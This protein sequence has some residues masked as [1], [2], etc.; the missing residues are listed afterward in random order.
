M[1]SYSRILL[2]Y[3]ATREGKNALRSGAALAQ[4]LKAETHLLAVLDN[5]G[6][7]AGYEAPLIDIAEIRQQTAQEIL[8]EGVADL[9]SRGVF[10]QGHLAIGNPMVQIPSF[11]KQLDIDLIVLGHHKR[12]G[13][14]R[15]WTPN[16]DSHLLDRVCC[17][18]LVVI[19]EG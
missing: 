7:A 16:A 6:W 15:W 2:C 8:K 18:V 13:L 10:A 3:N 1:A 14:S 19:D 9:A 12:G 11:A 5:A 4:E 17:S